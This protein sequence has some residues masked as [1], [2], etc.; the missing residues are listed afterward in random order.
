MVRADVA[1]RPVGADA[2]KRAGLCFAAMNT[3][4]DIRLLLERDVESFIREVEQFD[5][6]ELLWQT[7]PG[8]TNS[9]GNLAIH[10]AGNLQH[11]VGARLG[12]TG[13]VRDRE[14]EFQT[15]AGTRADVVRELHAARQ[16]VAWTL[17]HFDA[18]L[19]NRPMPGAPN[20]LTIPTGRFLLHL[21]A[22]TA[23]HLGQAGYLRRVLTG[24][25]AQSSNPMALGVLESR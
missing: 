10:I 17:T 1:P 22:H 5:T 12:G 7:L 21:V 6:D 3:L 4:A 19:L 14:R 20:N 16:A 18:S 13:Y 15:H 11:F 9:A 2:V 24:T 25:G 8:V 23:F